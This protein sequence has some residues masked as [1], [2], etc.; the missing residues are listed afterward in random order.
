MTRIQ[1]EFHHSSVEGYVPSNAVV[2]FHMFLYT[3]IFKAG[4]KDI[5]DFPSLRC[6]IMQIIAVFSFAWSDLIL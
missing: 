1:I 2:C 3:F 5:L 6:D 4:D